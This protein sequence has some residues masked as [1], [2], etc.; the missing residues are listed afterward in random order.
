MA[1]YYPEAEYLTN[2]AIAAVDGCGVYGGSAQYRPGGANERITS[3]FADVRDFGAVG[4]GVTDDAGAI[5]AAFLSA[6]AATGAAR[7]VYIPNGA[8]AS[9][10]FST[11]GG[12]LYG[13]DN[14]TIRGDGPKHESD[15]GTRIVNKSNFASF[16]IGS[17]SSFNY[18]VADNI[19]TAG[20]TKGSKTV[21]IADASPFSVGQ[22]CLIEFEN[23]EDDAL[24]L[25]GE[26][27]VLSVSGFPYMRRQ[28]CHI[29]GKTSTTLTF[30]QGI[31]HAPV[32]GKS[33]R[34]TMSNFPTTG[35][36]IEDLYID[37]SSAG[38]SVYSALPMND[39]Y[40]CWIHNVKCSYVNNYH[41]VLTACVACEITH[42]DFQDR[43]I[44]GTSG[45][46]I[47]MLKSTS[48]LIENN[49]VRNV[50]PGIEM[51]QGTCGC[52]ISHNFFDG[53]Y[54]GLNWNHGAHNSH[55]LFVGNIFPWMQSDGYFGSNSRNT[56]IRNW[57]V[58]GYLNSASVSD[59]TE[60][61]YVTSM[62]RFTRHTLLLG[63]IFG[64]STSIMA[65][66][67]HSMGEPFLGG[68]A[69]DGTHEIS[70][71]VF[72]RDWKMTAELTV[73]TSDTEGQMVLN[74]GSL[75]YTQFRAYLNIPYFAEL[76]ITGVN[77][78][79][80]SGGSGGTPP[81]KGLAGDTIY[82]SLEGGTLPTVGATLTIA[83]GILG[84]GD[85]DLDVANTTILKG[86][87]YN[88]AAGGNAIP[89]G[90]SLGSDTLAECYAYT[91]RPD[92]IPT[93]LAYPVFD[94]YD[95]ST[96]NYANHPAAY[97]FLNGVDAPSGT[98]TAPSITLQPVT[99]TVT[100]GDDV[101][102]AVNAT[103]NPT[104][105]YQWKKGGVDISGKT[106]RFLSLLD[107]TTGDAGSYA[108]VATNTEGTDT[109]AAAI[110]TVN[111]AVPGVSTPQ[112]RRRSAS[113]FGFNQL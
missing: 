105:A 73:R 52:V 96:A 58:G 17:A 64:R 91:S 9:S 5:Q 27:P 12:F 80:V 107:V 45:S 4:D 71:G 66:P 16:S 1:D 97:R 37:N 25:A 100:E 40:G 98:P 102:L 38:V 93:S 53:Q 99:Q 62:C 81:G 31:H 36:G 68:Q 34:V 70:A 23:V 112:P 56:F 3:L 83:G 77:G 41:A 28:T 33:A 110:L 24:L 69:A 106:T 75:Y 15:G 22:Q 8:W 57:G 72:P 47:L 42:C 30:S 46:G 108:C 94:P 92:W 49:I 18:P 20:L 86:N 55:N 104:P 48:C 19:I 50:N 29:V 109:S 84:Y 89:A 54:T 78:V 101:T 43:K 32:S 113:L 111:A 7:G 79:G 6:R 87:L 74:S 103:G 76:I 59:Y 10:G 35:V 67:V 44:G 85:I 95:S 61:A 60:I 2:W 13:N 63:N 82:F 88:Y 26:A 51:N 39:S 90:E 65:Y 11:I 21:T 14:I